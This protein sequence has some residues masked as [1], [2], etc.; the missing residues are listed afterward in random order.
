MKSFRSFL[1]MT[2]ISGRSSS[3][4]NWRPLP[5]GKFFFSSFFTKAKEK[6][7]QHLAQASKTVFDHNHR[8]VTDFFDPPMT[9]I[10]CKI[11]YSNQM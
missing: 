10:K 4:A 11:N 8:S 6:G 5:L 7:L 3:S 2:G 1:L 9:G